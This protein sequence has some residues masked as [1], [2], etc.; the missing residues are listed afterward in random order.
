MRRSCS[1]QDTNKP[2]PKGARPP[3]CPVRRASSAAASGSKQ[4]LSCCPLHLAGCLPHT[5]LQTGPVMNEPTPTRHPDTGSASLHMMCALS[6]CF[7][8]SSHALS[9][10][11]RLILIPPEHLPFRTLPFPFSAHT[12]HHQKLG[13]RTGCDPTT[14]TTHPVTRTTLIPL[15]LG[16]GSSP[17]LRSPRP[18]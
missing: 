4:P 11:T 13:A 6:A 5:P 8:G 10:T 16:R 7:I 9:H 15:A 18:P 12:Q 17:P 2:S 3:L 1:K 14:T